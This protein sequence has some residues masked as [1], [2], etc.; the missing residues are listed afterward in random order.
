MVKF[1]AEQFRLL[2]H[3]IVQ[4]DNRHENCDMCEAGREVLRTGLGLFLRYRLE[5]RDRYLAG[6]DTT[7]IYQGVMNLAMAENII[8]NVP[9]VA[10]QFNHGIAH[11]RLQTFLNA[12]FPGMNIVRHLGPDLPLRVENYVPFIEWADELTRVLVHLYK[13]ENL[14]GYMK[15]AVVL[16]CCHICGMVSLNPNMVSSLWSDTIVQ[17]TIAL[18]IAPPVRLTVFP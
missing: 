1:A 2:Y 8:R 18:A 3:H 9:Y 15:A 10:D 5:Q 6:S 4:Y 13:I 16:I 7:A 11:G 17:D 14:P 12:A